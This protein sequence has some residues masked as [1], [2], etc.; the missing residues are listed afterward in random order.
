MPDALVARVR[1]GARVTNSIPDFNLGGDVPVYVDVR[2]TI[3]QEPTDDDT[4]AVV[5]YQADG[6][7]LTPALTLTRQS[8]GVYYAS[9]TP[10]QA[11]LWTIIPSSELDYVEVRA[12][13]I[14]MVSATPAP[15]VVGPTAVTTVNGFPGPSIDLGAQHIDFGLGTDIGQT[16]TV[17]AYLGEARRNARQAGVVAD[18]ETD[19]TAALIRLFQSDW[20]KWEMP[21]GE[22]LIARPAAA[23]S[24]ANSGGARAF[25]TS[26]KDID[27]SGARFITDDLDAEMIRLMVP[28][29]GTGLPADLIRVRWRNGIIDQS[30][31]RVSTSVPS[32]ARW[33]P[34]TGKQGTAGITNGIGF[35]FGYTDGGGVTQAGCRLLEIDGLETYAGTHWAVAGGDSGVNVGG[36]SL[37]TVIKNTRHTAHRDLAY[38]LNGHP[39]N[40]DAFRYEVSNVECINCMFGIVLKRSGRNITIRDSR[41]INTVIGIGYSALDG[42][43]QGGVIEANEFNGVEIGVSAGLADNLRASRNRFPKLGALMDNGT[44]PVRYYGTVAKAYW[45]RG[46]TNSHVQDEHCAPEKDP[47]YTSF[48]GIELA[49]FVG[50]VTTPSTDNVVSN[51]TSVGMSD[52]VEEFGGADRNTIVRCYNDELVGKPYP[53]LIGPNTRHFPF[54]TEAARLPFESTLRYVLFDRA[55]DATGSAAVGAKDVLIFY[56]YRL[57]VPVKVNRLFAYVITGAAGSAM[58]VGIWKSGQSSYAEGL[59]ALATN[60]SVATT[61]SAAG[62]SW[63]YSDVLLP[64]GHYWIGTVFDASGSLPVMAQVPT[65][66]PQMRQSTDTAVFTAPL[67]G[68]S[69]PCV[70]STDLTTLNVTGLS[71]T[72]RAVS[73]GV[74]L[75]GVRPA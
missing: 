47:G 68:Y 2:D 57:D 64:P 13:Q 16:L 55:Y 24:G 48:H 62:V 15:A 72:S 44:S 11:G 73:F 20:P 50:D 40:P 35:N 4:I 5:V 39:T 49:D 12:R 63:T 46:V 70:F 28:S 18:G 71:R 43:V 36:G 7:V 60:T 37:L 26:D 3:T 6:E 34:P 19:D 59:P 29:G 42:E 30:N 38:Y 10:S 51:W 14:N 54:G 21:H 56:R 9:L 58:K 22:I 69:V 74:P 75:L 53:I 8:E 45:L 52:I 41:F 31:Q 27:A 32:A 66:D 25:L 33:L 1:F 61:S 17:A 65:P 23:P 67:A